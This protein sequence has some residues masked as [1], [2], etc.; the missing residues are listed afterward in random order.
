MLQRK[1]ERVVGANMVGLVLPPGP[2]LVSS[3]TGHSHQG[4]PAGGQALTAED[5][6]E[7]PPSSPP[8]FVPFVRLQTAGCLSETLDWHGCPGLC[9]V[10]RFVPPGHRRDMSS[11][12][13]KKSCFFTE[14]NSPPSG[15]STRRGRGGG[16]LPTFLFHSQRDLGL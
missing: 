15:L 13:G 14:S 5:S 11:S 1:R 4:G 8:T 3:V 16:S 7:K 6:A 12:L 10:S 9:S 2:G